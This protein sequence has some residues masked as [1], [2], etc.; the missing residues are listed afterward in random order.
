[1][2]SI[3]RTRPHTPAARRSAPGP[4]RARGRPLGRPSAELISDGVVAGYLHDI[5]QRHRG[6]S[7]WRTEPK[8]ACGG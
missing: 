3:I 7:L 2:T 6:P 8:A 1:M 5:S 4:D